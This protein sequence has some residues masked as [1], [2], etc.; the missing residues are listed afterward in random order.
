MKSLIS[1]EIWLEIQSD[2]QAGVG[3]CRELAEKYC[4]SVGAIQNRCKRK[5][6]RKDPKMFGALVDQRTDQKIDQLVNSKAETLA[7]KAERFI[8]RSVNESLDWMDQVQSA[9][10]KL[11]DG[12]IGGL[13]SLIQ[14]WEVPVRVGRA[15]LRLDE[16]KPDATGPA[17]NFN[18][19]PLTEVPA[20]A[21]VVDAETG[22][23]INQDK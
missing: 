14:A 22:Q 6:W 10:T 3:S 13:K 12:D 19:R 20:N 17:I 9:K 4:V 5:N 11:E 15:A 21:V 16:Q 1:K 2:Y 8:Q 18:I 23:V 7:K